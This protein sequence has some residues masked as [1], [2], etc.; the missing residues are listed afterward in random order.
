MVP[1][2]VDRAIPPRL[3]GYGACDMSFGATVTFVGC[4]CTGSVT[5][6]AE[7]LRVLPKI[8]PLRRTVKCDYDRRAH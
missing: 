4:P 8:C 6:E 2:Q 3:N 5:S 1:V 7:R